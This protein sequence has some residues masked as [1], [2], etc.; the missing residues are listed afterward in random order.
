[1][2][3]DNCCYETGKPLYLFVVKWGEVAGWINKYDGGSQANFL[4]LDCT[5][6]KAKFVWKPTQN[7]E[8]AM[9]KIAEW[10]CLYVKAFPLRN[11]SDIWTSKS[12]SLW[13]K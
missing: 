7:L 3:D 2:S 8:T 1:M 9:E 11:S 10:I 4:K 5:K 12:A 13:N 6:I